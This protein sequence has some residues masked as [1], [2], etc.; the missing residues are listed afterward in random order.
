MFVEYCAIDGSRTE[1]VGVDRCRRINREILLL[2]LWFGRGQILV[3]PPIRTR[4]YTGTLIED[5][6]TEE[7][8]ADSEYGPAD[9]Q[10]FR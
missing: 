7:P 5:E 2:G 1:I 4:D 10:A 6:M 9:R 3:H 8:A